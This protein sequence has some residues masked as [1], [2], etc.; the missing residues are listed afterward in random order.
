VSTP[1]ADVVA[2]DRY[3]EAVL[4]G[5]DD[6]STYEMWH[7]APPV[8][9]TRFSHLPLVRPTF[10]IN[11]GYTVGLQGALSEFADDSGANLAVARMYYLNEDRLLTAEDDDAGGWG[12]NGLLGY[13]VID[14]E[15]AGPFS[16][17]EEALAVANGNARYIGHLTGNSF[18]RG[19]PFHA[20]RFYQAFLSLP[21]LPSQVAAGAA[22]HG[23]VVVRRIPS[24]DHGTWFAVVNTGR[25]RVTGVTVA[26][27]TSGHLVDSASSRVLASGV[28]SWTG[29]LGP[30]ELRA[31]RLVNGPVPLLVDSFEAGLA[32]WSSRVGE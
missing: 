3:L 21:A 14:V 11:R 23:D 6:W 29:D 22:D 30:F 12:D 24:V 10:P 32:P 5:P 26:F 20:R 13:T 27:G 16:M 4:A 28:S 17:M 7:S 19:F 15:R 1:Y 2:E 18:T 25:Q 31:L 9:P 8:D